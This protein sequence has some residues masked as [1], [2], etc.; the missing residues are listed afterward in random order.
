MVVPFMTMYCTQQLGFSLLQAGF[1]MALFGAGA[2]TGAFIGGIIT[3][4]VGFYPMQVAALLLGGCMFIVT[5]FLKTYP[6]LCIGSFVLSVCN[7]SFR[8][9]NS[10]AV[11]FY[12]KPENRTRSYALNRLAINLGWSFGGALGGF[13][14]SI[15]Y[16]LLFWVDGV[17]NIVA[18][19]LLMRLLPYVNHKKQTAQA[20]ENAPV[21]S[22]YRD[23]PYLFFTLLTILFA[24]CFFQL[25]TIQPVFFKNEWKLTEQMIGLL[26][27]L[28]GLIIV[29][30]E[31][32]IVYSIEGKRP[33]TFFIRAG[34]FTVGLSYALFNILPGVAVSAFVCVAVMTLGEILAMPF[35][36]TYWISR[37]S[38][39]NRG[40]YAAIYTIAWSIAQ[41][42]APS[43]GSYTA[44][45]FGFA[46]LW[47]M[48]AGIC[49]ITAIGFALLGKKDGQLTTRS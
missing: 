4:K 11:A 46:T 36:N 12:S 8:P 9:A 24:T 35:M 33:L 32:I 13:I 14:A 44:E 27:A 48:N 38:E 25:F 21:K 22:A 30:I 19:L 2:V 40:Q 5:G 23:V 18:A 16:N 47:W 7:E 20:A 43:F 28:N 17:T 31:M 1:I 39:N 29:V 3:D 10:A 26:M 15:N 49:T 42:T 34:V 6:A 45:K 41:I 37:T